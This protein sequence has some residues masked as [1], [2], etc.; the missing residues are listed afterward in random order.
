MLSYLH[1]LKAQHY[2]HWSS[3][4]SPRLARR[5]NIPTCLKHN[6]NNNNP[7]LY[8]AFHTQRTS[9]SASH[10]SPWSLGLQSLLKP[11]QLPGGEYAALSGDGCLITQQRRV[12]ALASRPTLFR[13]CIVDKSKS[14]GLSI[15]REPWPHSRVEDCYTSGDHWTFCYALVLL[16][17]LWGNDK[18]LYI[19]KFAVTPC[20]NNL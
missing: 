4:P 13:A 3:I 18:Y 7:F 12:K 11:S 20:N 15:T 17:T 2:H 5:W 6:I 9:Q 19:E 1:C 10:Y 14:K 16:W 8:S